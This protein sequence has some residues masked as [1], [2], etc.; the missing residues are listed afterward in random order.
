M[1]TSKSGSAA[2]PASGWSGISSSTVLP[3]TV[4][5]TRVSLASLSFIVVSFLHVGWLWRSH[6]YLPAS[7]SP[8]RRYEL[9]PLTEGAGC[10]V[11]HP[12]AAQN[13]AAGR[14][15]GRSRC[16]RRRPPR[17]GRSRAPCSGDLAGG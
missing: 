8:E 17:P 11:I 5:Y 6:P 9:L 15:A 12:V 16:T 10:V 2:S 14:H 3:V 4:V 13:P 7:L 1:N